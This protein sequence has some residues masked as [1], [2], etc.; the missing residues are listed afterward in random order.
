ME[1]GG[2]GGRC[3]KGGGCGRRGL[4]IYRS[5]I[6]NQMRTEKGNSSRILSPHLGFSSGLSLWKEN[7]SKAVYM[8]MYT[9]LKY[10]SHSRLQGRSVP[11]PPPPPKVWAPLRSGSP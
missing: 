4:V 7:D 11:P 3:V 10:D 8:Y 5:L 1:G 6:P 2:C 9:L